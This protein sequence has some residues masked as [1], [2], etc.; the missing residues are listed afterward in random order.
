[1]TRF[2]VADPDDY[3]RKALTL[4]LKFRLHGEAIFEAVDGKEL[5]EQWQQQPLDVILVDWNLPNLPAPRVF[6]KFLHEHPDT[7]LVLLSIDNSVAMRAKSYGACFIYKA[8]SAKQV[9]EHLRTI[10][11]AQCIC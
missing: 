6:L 11:G 8:L 7:T 2:L 10:S 9:L 5:V 4:L 1:M 3:S